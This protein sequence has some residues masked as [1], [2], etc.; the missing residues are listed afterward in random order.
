MMVEKLLKL[1]VCEVNTQLFK[2]VEIENFETS[3][4]KNSDEKVASE[5][6]SQ[7]T[8][9]DVYQ[10]FKNALVAGFSD[11]TKGV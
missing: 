6:S 2:S 4:V 7:G 8:V 11:S 1:F 5:I 10:P 9:D 3:D